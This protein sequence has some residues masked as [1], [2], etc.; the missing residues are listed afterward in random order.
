MKQRFN[1][2]SH[3]LS[4]LAV[5]KCFE[6]K[7]HRNDVLSFIE[8]WTGID[9]RELWR[10]ELEHN[11]IPRYAAIDSVALVLDDVVDGL[12]HG[13]EPDIDPVSTRPRPDGMTNKI[14]NIAYLCIMHQLIGHVVKLGLDPL[15]RARLLPTQHA[16]IPGHGQTRLTRQ[17]RRYLRCKGLGIR[18]HQKTDCTNAY[19]SMM[20]ADIIDMI[21]QEI[22]KARWIIAC[23]QFLGKMAP[24]GHLIIGGYLDAW[25]FNLALSYALRDTL[26]Q[27][28]T[29]RGRFI[30]YVERIESFMDDCDMMARTATGIK[31]AVK[32]LTAWIAAKYHV[33][34]RLTTGIIYWLQPQ[35]ERQRRSRASPAARGCPGLDMGGYRIFRTH[36]TMRRRVAKR[37]IRAFSR[38][39]TEYKR[40]GTVQRQRAV[41]IVCRHG[42]IANS[43]SAKFKAKYHVPEL[44]R[45]SVRVFAYWQ[46]A[47]RRKRKEKM[48]NAVYQRA[49]HPGAQPCAAGAPA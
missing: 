25:L 11:F 22:P 46:R 4:W 8:E 13:I 10:A 3:D 32:Y 17:A 20:Y 28:K 1:K 16:S 41:S 44:M 49:S 38:A 12:M 14:R 37:V 6:K 7:W 36:I 33:K 31:R 45:V 48:Q 30:P 21:R 39:W 9:R 27:G 19:G 18:C 26:R 40:T 24:G 47:T 23:L 42:P 15:L 5:D 43:S 29:R 2:Y 34:V 35:E